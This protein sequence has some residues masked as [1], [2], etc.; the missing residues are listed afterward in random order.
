MEKNLSRA[1]K[2]ETYRKRHLMKLSNKTLE[3]KAIRAFK[4]LAENMGKAD[5]N[6]FEVA[7]IAFEAIVEEMGLRNM[8]EPDYDAIEINENAEVIDNTKLVEDIFDINK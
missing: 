7:D 8:K 4:W 3:S 2:S 6:K 1:E 5:D